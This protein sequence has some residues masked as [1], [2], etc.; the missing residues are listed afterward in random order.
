MNCLFFQSPVSNAREI[1]GSSL[2]RAINSISLLCFSIFL[3]VAFSYVQLHYYYSYIAP[4]C[5]VKK[6]PFVLS[7]NTRG[8]FDRR[9]HVRTYQ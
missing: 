5:M 7:V 9:A 2:H 3:L 6:I 1:L 4:L 8:S